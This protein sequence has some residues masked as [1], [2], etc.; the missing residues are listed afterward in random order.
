[1]FRTLDDL[2]PAK[3]VLVRVDLN[4]PV[5]RGEVQDNKRFE[6]HA[7]T[8]AELAAADHRIAVL[9]HQGRPGRDTFVDL[10]QHAEI[11]SGYLDRP[12][13]YVDSV[14][15][16]AAVAAIDRLTAGDIAL[17]AN[18]RRLEDELAD[19]TPAGHADSDFVRTLAPH[20][21]AFVNDAYSTA[22]RE[23][24]STVGFPLVLPAYAGRVMEAEY[25]ANTAIQS[26]SFD[27]PVTMIL[28]GTKSDDLIG[29][30]QGVEDK[31]D[32]ACLGGVIGE[33]FLRAESHS[34]GYDVADLDLFDRQWER[35]RDAIESVLDSRPV[36]I[37][38]P[39]DLAYER[40]GERVDVS[41]DSIEKERPL[42]DVGP[43]TVSTYV[44]V[45]ENS[46]AVFVKGA[47]GVFEEEPFSYGTVE[48]LRAI[49]ATDAFS[50]IGGGDTAWAVDRYGLDPADFDHLS[51]A[52]GAY[53]RA[54]A[55]ESLP[56]IDVLLR[57]SSTDTGSDT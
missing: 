14:C 3:R 4:S 16:E 24:A 2:A 7:E 55:G 26:R 15:D 54:L 11:L 28:G 43:E 21:D 57:A 44:D 25:T 35:N 29:V 6:R 9:A 20:F 23:H 50:V 52:G 1:M 39:I 17:L 46:S 27:G 36:S 51:I 34:V 40:D 31:V 41:V 42:K 33:L 45:I 10:D 5:E 19:R 32:T 37:A 48:V 38:T 8:L 22:H 18:V 47:L 13:T 12:V 30:L 56:A 49:A 53:V